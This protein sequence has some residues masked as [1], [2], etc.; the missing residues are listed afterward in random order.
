[1]SGDG[2]IDEDDLKETK[3]DLRLWKTLI[4][5]T[6]HYRRTS[7]VFVFV[8]FTLAASDLGFPLLTGL[9]IQDIEADP[10]NLNFP[11]YIGMFALLAVSLSASIC[12]FVVCAGK[13]RTSVS[14]DIRRDAFQQLQRLSFSYFDTR[15]TGWLMARLTSDCQRLSVILAWGVM[16]FIW[17]T[18]LMT[19]ISVVMI[20]INWKIAL[21]IF[22]VIP[23]LFLVSLHFKKK[24]LRTSRLVRKT[25]SRITGVYNEGIMG[26]QTS[27]IFVREEENLRDFDLLTEE[28]FQYSVRNAMLSAVYLPLVLTLGSVAIAAALV[29]GGHQAILGNIAI[30]EMIMF[31]YFAQLFFTPA[32]EISAWFAELQMAQASAERVLSLIES[33]PEVKNTEAVARRI[34]QLGSDGHPTKIGRIEFRD[35]SFAYQTGPQII[36]NFSL[37]V[38]PGE[39]I[40]LVGATGGGKST[41]VNLLC[42]F[43]EPTEGQ[44]LID[45]VDY[46]DRS[47]EGF[48]SQ[49]GIVLQQPHLFSGTIAEN[50]RYGKLS[51][52]DA[53]VEEAARF[54]GA[55]EFISVLEDGY[56][57]PVGEGGN[58]LSL[59]QKQLVSF[60]RTVL[61]RPQLL[62]MD[63]ATSSIDTETEQ[64]I[65][66]SLKRILK[67]RTSFVI[68]HRLSTI[69]A[70]DRIL[71][72]NNGEIVEQGSHQELLKTRGHY[73]ELYKAQAIRDLN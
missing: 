18:T 29:V 39:T 10:K 3:L 15:P 34:E 6:L 26:V 35:I 2:W 51:A 57:T 30:G 37:T 54:A 72:I 14:H 8:A 55:H 9:L 60:A 36:R 32:Q 27:K 31:M 20:I 67:E 7:I 58:Q 21:A 17:G 12:A 69:Q 5:Y 65:Q 24:I 40:A 47:L 70:A 59:G 41:M 4:R 63:E 44:I 56:Q 61:K 19:S 43:Y 42:R 62:V 50:I 46:T 38:E 25:N 64:L 11:F 23:V 66:N 1:M 13:I 68:A 45:G 53:E 16:D 28:M 49:L 71:V 33:V 22:S 48:Q 52:S 73:F